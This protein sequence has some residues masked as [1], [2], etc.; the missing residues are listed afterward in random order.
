MTAA[1][2]LRTGLVIYELKNGNKVD[3]ARDL[4]FEERNFIQ[5]MLIYRYLNISLADFRKR[6]RT[7]ECPLWSGPGTLTAPSPAV[8]ILLDLEDQ[9]KS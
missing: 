4:N 9:L 6:W 8:Q 2:R 7:P 5:K 3:T 1:N